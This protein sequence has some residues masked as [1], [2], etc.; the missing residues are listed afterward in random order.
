MV[1]HIPCDNVNYGIGANQTLVWNED[2]REMSERMPSRVY[3]YEYR[4]VFQVIT[5]YTRSTDE[6]IVT[7]TTNFRSCARQTQLGKL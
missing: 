3:C 6:E 4:N 2:V 1:Y 7:C 5:A